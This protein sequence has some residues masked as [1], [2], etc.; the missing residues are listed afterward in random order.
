[1]TVLFVY[2]RDVLV[3][4]A[5]RA[6]EKAGLSFESVA[7]EGCD[8]LDPRARVVVLPIEDVMRLGAGLPP[9]T[10]MVVYGRAS[11]RGQS[12]FPGASFLVSPFRV[13][14]LAGLL[15]SLA[16]RTA[17]S[18]AYAAA[19]PASPGPDPQAP[20]QPA[21]S[22]PPPSRT[23][24]EKPDK[25]KIL[26]VDDD[27]IIRRLYERVLT[28]VGY[29]VLL[30]EDGE[31]AWQKI[32]SYAPDLVISDVEMPRVDGYELCRRVKEYPQ[33]AQTPFIICSSLSGGRDVMRAFESGTDDYL[34]KPINEDELLGRVAE[35]LATIEQGGRELILVVDDSRIVRNLVRGGLVKQGF[36]VETAVDGRDALDK[37]EAMTEMP[38]MIISDFEMPR[39]NG[40]ELGMELRARSATTGIPLIVMSA[41]DD[42]R[43]KSLMKT[44][45]AV[46]YI[47]K[48]FEPDKVV[49]LVERVLAEQRLKAEKA[50]IRELVADDAV[51]QAVREIR[52]GKRSMARTEPMTLLFSDLKGF[53]TMCTRLSAETVVNL[54]NGYFDAMIPP[55]LRNQ[56]DVDKFI[57]DAIMARF[58][59][60]DDGSREPSP[61]RAIRAALDMQEALRQYN[62]TQPGDQQLHMRVG[63]NHGQVVIGSIGA[64]S[65]RDYTTIGDEVNR[66]QRLESNAQVDGVCIA[67]STYRLVQDRVVAQP[68]E[69]RIQLKGIAEPVQVYD[70]VGIRE[71]EG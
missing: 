33:W 68:R 24:P 65:R 37:L 40:F 25:Y 1:M 67:E 29:D 62:R 34:I 9:S 43:Y 22:S 19:Q 3:R 12:T 23:P 58:R 32:A 63:I 49:A 20:A 21:P 14:D 2:R 59:D 46:G 28:E 35:M 64:R 16:P 30:A 60:P 5:A 38:S 26:A 57:G 15:E 7:A 31:D 54:L 6:A 39:M 27:R 36:E 71:E 69:Q 41:R 51:A 56:G 18:P 66:A 50:R 11:E 70:V 47:G 52:L 10:R 45:G 55:I 44:A 4:V 13:D 48:P 42:K 53:S 17:P 61:L 8:R